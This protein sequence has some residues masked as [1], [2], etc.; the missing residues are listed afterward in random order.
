MVTWRSLSHWATP[1]V[2]LIGFVQIVWLWL[3]MN[4]G[5]TSKLNVNDKLV[6]SEGSMMGITGLRNLGNTCY[7]NSGLQCLSNIPELTKYFLSG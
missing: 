2:L 5:Y 4:S 7:I 3:V 1:L 6:Q